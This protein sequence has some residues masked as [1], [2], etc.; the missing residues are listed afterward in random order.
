MRIVLHAIIRKIVTEPVYC[1]IIAFSLL[2][3][4]YYIIYYKFFRKNV[5]IRFPFKAFS[6]VKIIGP[7]T[8][9]IDSNSSVGESVFKGLTI[10]TLSSNAIVDIGKRCIL[11]GL[12]IRCN[13]RVEIK[14]RTISANS[15]VQD[16]L[17]I[18]NIKTSIEFEKLEVPYL[19]PIKIG[20]NVWLGGQSIVLTGS[21][22]DSG[23]VLGAGALCYNSEIK[24]KSLVIGNPA[25][26][27]LPISNVLKFKER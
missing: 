10:V 12:T 23:S 21:C 7:G 17:F 19:K 20:E 27:P 18:N 6:K 2:R 13:D 16:T 22:I 3:G 8:V 1:V 5:N 15:L 26:R 11:Q 14:E 9:K 4:T 25:K 24:K